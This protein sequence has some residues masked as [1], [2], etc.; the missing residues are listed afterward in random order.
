MANPLGLSTNTATM[1]ARSA[2]GGP[3]TMVSPPRALRGLP[4][5]G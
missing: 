2:A 1:L 5:P 4:H 3:K